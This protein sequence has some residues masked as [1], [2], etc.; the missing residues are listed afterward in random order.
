MQTK[1]VFRSLAAAVA[2]MAALATGAAHG[3]STT[4]SGPPTISAFSFTQIMDEIAV[5]SNQMSQTL[6]QQETAALNAIQLQARAAQQQAD[7]IQQG[8]TGAMAAATA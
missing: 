3:Q 8:S 4:N 1:G 2:A 7:D 6:A 5:L